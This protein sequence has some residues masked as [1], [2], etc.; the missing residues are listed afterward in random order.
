MGD[1]YFKA[2]DFLEFFSI[3]RGLRD[4][5]S[6]EYRVR[7][8]IHFQLYNY[9]DSVFSRGIISSANYPSSISAGGIFG[10]EGQA[11][12]SWRNRTEK[13]HIC[14]MHIACKIYKLKRRR[15]A[16][17]RNFPKISPK[18]VKFVYE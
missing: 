4:I 8:K 1:S 11:N 2:G 14:L 18:C 5:Y 12:K 10:Q 7:E 15:V 9:F 13:Y 6:V 16:S 3:L 17:S